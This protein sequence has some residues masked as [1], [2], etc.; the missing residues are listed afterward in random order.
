MRARLIE[1]LCGCG[2]GFYGSENRK[3]LKNLRRSAQ[4][5]RAI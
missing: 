4:G 2:K 3:F 5:Q 1:A